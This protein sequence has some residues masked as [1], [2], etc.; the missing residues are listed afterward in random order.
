MKIFA[1]GG[2]VRDAILSLE[3]S[4]RDFVVVGSTE[5]EMLSLGFKNVGAAFPVFLHPETGDEYALARKERKI[6]TGYHGFAVEFDPTVTLEEDL[7]RRDLSIN[8]IAQDLETGEFID[9]FNGI[10]DLKNG[11]LR[12]TSS[13]FKEDPLRVIRLAR[14]FAR[15]SDFTI[16]TETLMVVGEVVDG[17][18]LN[19]LPNE[20]FWAEIEKMFKQSD[21]PHRFFSALWNFGVFDKVD[22]FR[23][24][25]GTISAHKA[26]KEF[27]AILNIVNRE[28]VDDRLSMFVAL[29]ASWD[30]KQAGQACPTNVS[31]LTKAVKLVRMLDEASPKNVFDILMNIRGFSAQSALAPNLIRVLD[32]GERAGMNFAIGATALEFARAGGMDISSE[33]FPDLE[34]RALGN[35]I[36]A[37]RLISI[38]NIMKAFK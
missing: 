34:G 4:D 38:A 8:S 16:A 6:G 2:A 7:S 21:T 10:S 9:P 32:I 27:R 36:D 3:C 14:L 13:A 11:V 28:P 31:K 33:L 29:A 20:R 23:D 5:A 24:T 19:A 25:F 37:A 18:E 22:F 15:F 30:A 35:A 12:H 1:V 17:G 26:L